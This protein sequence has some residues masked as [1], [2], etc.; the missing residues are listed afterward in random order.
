MSGSA[1][2]RFSIVELLGDKLKSKDD[3]EIAT[4]SICGE[5]KYVGLYFSA[6][7][8][9]PC[10]AFTPTLANFYNT[11]TVQKGEKLLEIVF[12]SSDKNED[13]FD[14]YYNRMPWL[15]LPYNLRDKKNEVS[16]RFKVSAIPTLIILDSVTGEV[17]CVDGVDEVKCDGEGK[18]FPWKSRPFPEIITGNFINQEMKTVTSESLKDKVLG[19]YFSAHWCPPCRVFT[20]EL[21]STYDK[22]KESGQ[23]FEI[24]FASRD[25]AEDAFK[26][27]FGEMPWLGFPFGDKRIGELAKLFSVQGIP[28]LAIVDA[29]GKVITADARGSVTKDPEGKEFPWYPKACCEL[30]AVSAAMVNV[31]SCLILFTEIEEDEE[32][33]ECTRKAMEMMKPIAEETKAAEEAKGQE[34]A[35]KFIVAGDD[36]TVEGLQQFLSIADES[37]PMLVLLDIPRER[38]SCCEGKE[39]TPD[40]IREYYSKFV[41]D[42]LQWTTLSP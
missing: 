24:I 15:A 5:G 22:I 37:L 29:Q 1:S 36:E 30:D 2:A 41:K 11:S 31:E 32:G 23:S 4:A 18:K 33:E 17:T 21:K 3:G 20:K 38:V 25:R 16:R 26:N 35:C 27:Y 14:E 13:Q 28:K 34:L 42:E 8:C 39:I 12:I 40:L 19:I 6:H 7:W 9:P 10:Q